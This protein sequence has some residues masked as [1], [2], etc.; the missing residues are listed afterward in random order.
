M[1][2][3]H[4]FKDQ[5]PLK[6]RWVLCLSAVR[7]SVLP[8][9]QTKRNRRWI[10]RRALLNNK[11]VLPQFWMGILGIFLQGKKKWDGPNP[12]FHQYTPPF[13]TPTMLISFL[14]TLFN[15]YDQTCNF[16]SHFSCHMVQ[17]LLMPTILVLVS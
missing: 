2:S 11:N 3:V 13:L 1:L 7:L 9:V 17:E 5:Q 6:M 12:S 4:L 8:S 10:S 16:V 15:I 14:S